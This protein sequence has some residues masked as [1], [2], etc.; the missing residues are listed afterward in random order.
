MTAVRA[1][2]AVLLAAGAV[3][4]VL[5]A[6]DVRSWRDA[7]AAGDAAYVATPSRASWVPHTRVGGAAEGLVGTGDDVRLRRA[8]QFFVDASKLHLRLDNAVEVESAHA[9]A[10]DAL[11]GVA[12]G[13]D[14]QRAS[15]ALTLL[16]ILAYRAAAAGG[17]RS[18]VD[19]AIS[20][21][22]DAVRADP[23]NENAAY[24]LELLL[25]RIAANGSRS[26]P[27]QGNGFGRGGRRGGGGGQPGNGY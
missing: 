14:G 22:T 18:E 4:A 13:R 6:G 26:A 23:N 12:R 21:F 20:D 11:E 24:D 2:L 1:A 5:L 19:A 27:G 3:V 9:R 17:A 10:Q 16:G 8:L 7:L 25:R 15:Q